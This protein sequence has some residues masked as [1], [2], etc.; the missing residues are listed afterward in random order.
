MRQR[1][2]RH[3]RPHLLF[4]HQTR[5]GGFPAC[6]F[7]LNFLDAFHEVGIARLDAHCESCIAFGVFMGAI[8]KRDFSQ[9]AGRCTGIMYVRGDERWMKRN[10]ERDRE[11]CTSSKPHTRTRLTPEQVTHILSCRPGDCAGP[12]GSSSIAVAYPRTCD[13]SRGRISCPPRM[14]FS[15]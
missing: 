3:L 6:S 13:R 2:S 8:Y 12:G 4:S 15:P 11:N 10:N 5:H 7:C 9:F 1:T 14:R